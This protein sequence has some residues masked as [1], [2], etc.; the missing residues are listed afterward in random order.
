M[1][2]F[3]RSK[4]NAVY[5]LLGAF[6]IVLASGANSFAHKV[7]IFAYVEGDLVF[8]ESYFPDGRKVEKSTIEVY[9]S[10]KNKLLTGITDK[11]GVFN[12]RP[13]KKDDLKIVII[14][15]MGHKNSYL[16]SADE[17]PDTIFTSK[18]HPPLLINNQK[19]TLPVKD[20]SQKTS[21]E[22]PQISR[23]KGIISEYF[24]LSGKSKTLEEIGVGLNLTKERVRQIKEKA[25]RKL[26]NDSIELFEY[27]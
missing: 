24:G 7:N 1:Y 17:L 16:L 14:A 18:T 25:L 12:F 27:M 20:I 10:Q 19:D 26:R 13:P 2:I 23:E 5:G 8:T 15:G 21:N 9:D 6:F 4:K 11:K 3:F 22:S